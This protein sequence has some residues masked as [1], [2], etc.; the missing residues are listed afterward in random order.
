MKK[1]VIIGGGVGA[2]SFASTASK[3]YS[4]LDVTMV[5]SNKRGPVPCGIPYA[6]GSM[7]NPNDNQSPDKPFIE[8]GTHLLIEDVEQVDPSG[9][10]ILLKSG[11]WMSYD[12]LVMATGST[13]IFPPFE[14]KDLSGIHVIEKDLDVVVAL[15]KEVEAAKD[16]VIVGGGFIGVE[17]ADEISHWT[18]KNITLVEL[19][20]C[21]LSVA[22]EPTYSKKIEGLLQGK[23]INVRTGVGMESFQ[24]DEQGKVNSVTLSNGERLTADLVFMAIGAKP[25]VS[26]AKEAGLTVDPFGAVQ[27]NEFQQT[28]DENI[29]AVGDCASKIDLYNKKPSNIRLASVAAREGRNAAMNI[30]SPV[31][32]LNIEGITNLFS[33]A[34]E[35]VYF[36]AV[37]MTLEQIQKEGYQAVTVHVNEMNRHPAGLPGSST[38]DGTFFFRKED[39]LLLGAQLEGKEQIAEMINALGIAVQNQ[40][41]AYDLFGYNYGTH[42]LGTTSPNKYIFHQAGTKAIAEGANK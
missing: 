30:K 28:S 37:G 27:V 36:G 20:P 2:K 11:D 12:K 13:P 9:K 7:E 14:G 5:R 4:D 26:L 1:V 25:E 33:T 3:L 16:V 15:R 31:R 8:A 19:A 39:L 29:Y 24:G 22:F 35:G 23:N 6:L 18:G 40:D 38:I 41:T 21:C 32:P 17:L 42:P 10:R 34:V